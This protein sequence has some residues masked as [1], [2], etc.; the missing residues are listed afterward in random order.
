MKVTKKIDQ[1]IEL[2]ATDEITIT[3]RKIDQSS[4]SKVCNVSV[5]RSFDITG[6]VSYG[7]AEVTASAT[8]QDHSDTTSTTTSTHYSDDV[9]TFSFKG[10]A[11]TAEIYYN[12]YT[13]SDVTTLDVAYTFDTI[14]VRAACTYKGDTGITFDNGNARHE[15][16][17]CNLS[18]LGFNG[19]VIIKTPVVFNISCSDEWMSKDMVK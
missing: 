12:K 18:D 6:N 5:D 9:V 2:T 8:Y 19:P 16:R 3:K 13:C 15:S 17:T 11:G 1:T 7:A 10:T 4:A 14:T